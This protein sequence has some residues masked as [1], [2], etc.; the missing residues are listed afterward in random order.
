MEDLHNFGSNYDRT[1]MGWFKNFDKHWD[2]L[3]GKYGER[4]Y[5]M[6]K[7]YLLSSA[8]GFRSRKLQLWQMVLS[9][10]GIPGGYKS[11]R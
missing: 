11:V 3:K 9:K 1:L 8:G 7:F 10:N 5:R 6:W 4:F 2:K